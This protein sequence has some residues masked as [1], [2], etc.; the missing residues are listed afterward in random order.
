LRGDQLFNSLAEVLNI[1]EA[2]AMRKAGKDNNYRAI[3]AGPRGQLNATFG[4]DPS[5]RRDEIA[6]SIPQA[7]L[8]MNGPMLGAAM[9]ARAPNGTLAQ[10]LASTKDDQA[11]VQELYLR[12]FGREA[13]ADETRTCVE[14]VKKVGNRTEAFE[15]V[16]WA[17]V[18]STEFLNRK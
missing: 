7:L 13:T 1:N 6:G 14:Y 12:A 16:L 18:N 15:D 17:L 8:L 4:Y 3:L 10:V 5:E 11:V 2:D 9:S